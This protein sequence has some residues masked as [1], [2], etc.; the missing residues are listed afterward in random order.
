[1]KK[2]VFYFI[3]FCALMVLDGCVPTP[4]GGVNPAPQTDSTVIFRSF[5]DSIAMAHYNLNP[6]IDKSVNIDLDSNGTNDI[7]VYIFS[8]EGM[9]VGVINPLNNCTL[10]TKLDRNYD[11]FY[12]ANDFINNTGYAINPGNNYTI[13]LNNSNLMGANLSA[14]N[15]LLGFTLLLPDGVHYGWINISM[16]ASYP[17]TI[18]GIGIAAPSTVKCKINSMAYKIASNT[19][20]QAGKY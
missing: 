13:G 17:P 19:A 1:M 2:I 11:A 5:T 7:N 20:I 15:K 14:Y 8:G 18:M 10:L 4:G 9:A 16:T 3:S 6:Y 12:V